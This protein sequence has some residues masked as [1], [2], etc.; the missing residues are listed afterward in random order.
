MKIGKQVAI[1]IAASIV[2]AALMASSIFAHPGFGPG[3]FGMMRRMG[4]SLL[5]QLQVSADQRSQIQNLFTDGRETIRPL[6]Q[7]LREKHTV[8][9]EA[10]RGQPFDETLVRS[11]AQEIAD[12]QARLM[13]ARAQLKNQVLAVLTDEQQARLGELRAQRLQQF[14][15]W[16][17]ERLGKTDPSQQQ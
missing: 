16:R 8:L 17:K 14:R 12:V 4:P 6:I 2:V 13:V 3:R 9:Q 5:D 15:E 10:A 1:G 7:Q 11:Q